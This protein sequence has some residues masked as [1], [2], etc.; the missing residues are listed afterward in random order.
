[1]HSSRDSALNRLNL[2]HNLML[3]DALNHKQSMLKTIADTNYAITL[4]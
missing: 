3:D 1:M 2:C 4:Q